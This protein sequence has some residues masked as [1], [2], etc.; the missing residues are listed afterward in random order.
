MLKQIKQVSPD[1]GVIMISGHGTFD[2]ALEAGHLGAAD[3]LGKP[4]S[5]EHILH[6]V[7][8]VCAKI[9]IKHSEPRAD[10]GT[11]T[12]PNYRKQSTDARDF[13]ENSAGRTN[14]RTCAHHG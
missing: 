6:P 13:V 9:A 1:T 7:E 10:T 2:L 12:H 5:L 14:K 4:L 11:Q 3:V 8:K